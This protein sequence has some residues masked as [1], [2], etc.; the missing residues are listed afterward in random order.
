MGPSRKQRIRDLLQP[1]SLLRKDIRRGKLRVN[2]TGLWLIVLAGLT[3]LM[4]FAEQQL[5]STLKE[6]RRTEIEAQLETNA[7]TLDLWIEEFEREAAFLARI[8]RLRAMVGELLTARSNMSSDSLLAYHP[9]QD[10]IKSMVSEIHGR[11]PFSG[12]LVV[13]TDGT[14]LAATYTENVG[15]QFNAQVVQTFLPDIWDQGSRFLIPQAGVNWFQQPLR[16][17]NDQA[18]VWAF[19]PIQNRN[20]T[21]L[22]LLGLARPASDEFSDI[23]KTGQLGET[24]EAYAVGSLGELLSDTRFLSDVQNSRWGKE[25]ADL[26]NRGFKIADPAVRITQNKLPPR[27]L[28]HW[29]LTPPAAAIGQAFHQPNA[30]QSGILLTPYRDYRGEQVIGGWTYLHQHGMGIVVEMD[31]EEAYRPLGY[32]QL[33]YYMA[34]LVSIVLAGFNVYSG[35][36]IRRLRKR[37]LEDRQIGVYRVGKQLAK[38]GMGEIYRAEHALLKRPTALKIMRRGIDADE[39]MIQNF[40]REVTLAAR[41]EHPNTISVYDYGTTPEGDFFY[42]MELLEGVTLE[43]LIQ[44]EGAQPPNRVYH[45]VRQVAAS[46]EEAH[47]LGLVH[48]DIKP[49]N[50]MLCTIA[51]MDDVVKVL[52]FGLAHRVNNTPAGAPR[53]EG[54]LRYMAPEQILR[55]QTTRFSV[56]I[57]GLGI[58]G[59]VLL[60]GHD[61][62]VHDDET[63]ML[64]QV[65]NLEPLPLKA[66]PASDPLVQL[67]W[68][69]LAKNPE[70]R[71]SSIKAFVTQLNAIAQQPYT[72]EQPKLKFAPTLHMRVHEVYH[73]QGTR[74]DQ[75]DRYAVHANWPL[76][77]VADGMGGHPGGGEA[78]SLL[79]QAL[80]KLEAGAGMAEINH[81]VAEARRSMTALANNRPGWDAM[82][83]TLT[84][85]WV[86]GSTLHVAWCGDSRVYRLRNGDRHQLTQD[87]TRDGRLTQWVGPLGPPEPLEWTSTEL[88]PGDA[89]VLCSDGFYRVAEEHHLQWF[90]STWIQATLAEKADDNYTAILLVF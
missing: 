44:Q 77:A 28:E 6:I 27:S 45:I 4:F 23:F 71:P 19:A 66:Y 39:A 40:Q 21:P 43:E 34:L 12:F 84:L 15:I 53:L 24:G 65:I 61:P 72:K 48:R 35:I 86:S 49:S 10:S 57:Y 73:G 1:F 82:G 75:Q 25:H 76:V 7:R 18:N 26:L 56:D 62:F 50:I 22:G 30:E 36:T 14:L 37:T 74:K 9:M 32:L 13:S 8:P 2:P 67:I 41:L 70:D 83:T 52:D 63:D 85:A 78:A 81:A 29:P 68:S 17:G 47:G 42:A 89:I 60:A 20:G 80:M 64:T 51:G 88:Q 79:T 31:A 54:T 38:G 3:L 69:C 33:P 16:K 59:Y 87:H 46:L 90:G 11:L 5:R 55:P 58:L